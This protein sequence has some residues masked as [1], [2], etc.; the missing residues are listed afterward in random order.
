MKFAAK[1]AESLLVL[2]VLLAASS[3]HADMLGELSPYLG[4]DY[5]QTWMRAQSD[6]KKIFPR[7]YRGATVYVGTRFCENTLGLEL[8]Y[9]RSTRTK[10]DWSLPAGSAFFN[11]AV[12][13][14]GI[15]GTTKV[16]RSGVHL[17]FLGFLPI[18]SCFD[19]FAVV[20]YGW[21]QNKIDM[22]LSTAPGSSNQSS[23]LATVG[24]KGGSVLRAGLGGS[25]MVNDMVGLRA[26]IGWETTSTLRV[27]GN[28]AFTALG[29]Q[30]KG[31]KDTTALS[32]G[33]FVKF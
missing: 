2:S 17:D 1:Q 4:A 20:G 24:G 15:T 31:W 21:V 3:A 32:I 13:N 9:D 33:A 5:Y 18:T 29:Y 7:S 22:T 27:K 19:L 8:G 26:K 25:Y 14:T 16:T 30:S 28:Q 10:K 12:P 11:G 6:W 23:A